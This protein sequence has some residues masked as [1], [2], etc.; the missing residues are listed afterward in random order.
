MFNARVKRIGNSYLITND[1]GS[2]VILNKSD[3]L[4]FKTKKY[5]KKLHQILEENGI[6]VTNANKESI[7]RNYRRN[8]AQIFIGPSLHIVVPTRRCNLLCKY[9]QAPIVNTNEFDMTEKTAKNVVDFIFKSP[10]KNLKIEFQGGEPLLNFKIV[11]YIVNYA[12]KKA[13]ET[14][15]EIQFTMVSNLTALTNEKLDFL[16]KNRVWLCTSLDGPREL[17]E[18]NRPGSYDALKKWIPIIQKRMRQNLSAIAV[19]SKDSLKYPKE[20]IREYKKFGFSRIWVKPVRAIGK[21]KDEKVSPERYIEFW[22]ELINLLINEKI[23]EVYTTILIKKAIL[24]ENPLF[25]DLESPCGA[26]ISQLAYEYNG[27]VYTCD[28]GRMIEDDVFKLGNVVEDYKDIIHSGKGIIKCSQNELLF[29]KR[30]AFKPFC[31]VCPVASFAETGS[32]IPKIGNFDCKVVMAQ[33][34]FLFEKF[35]SEKSYEK[36]FLKWAETKDL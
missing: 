8:K 6:I 33:F 31:G 12:I 27:D 24:N 13:R 4:L 22:K 20:I 29:C 35:F 26:V 7:I 5:T 16:V 19:I 23:S 25:T 28:E 21:G 15:K 18:K 17:Q 34:E 2:Y 3:Y 14:D 36:M 11:K 1:A 32:P 9:C 30:C 10:K